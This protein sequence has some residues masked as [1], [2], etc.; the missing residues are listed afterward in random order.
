MLDECN[1]FAKSRMVRDCLVKYKDEDF[2][3]RINGAKVGDSVQYNLPTILL[4]SYI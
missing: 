1:S 3:I 4:A 2:I